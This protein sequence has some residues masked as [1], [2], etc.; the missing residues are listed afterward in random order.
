MSRHR[1]IALILGMAASLA[2]LAV[3]WSGVLEPVEAVVTDLQ[4]RL[5][6]PQPADERV[7]LVAVDAASIDALGRWPW[8]RTCLA[9]LV[10]RLVAADAR[11]V[12]FD[13]VLSEAT[14]SPPGVDLSGEDEALASSLA[15]APEVV[16][17][18]FFRHRLPPDQREGSGGCGP[19][20]LAGGIGECY[21]PP[22]AGEGSTATGP[23][24]PWSVQQVLGGP[25]PVPQ[26]P[27]VEANLELFARQVSAQGFFS[28][29]RQQG[30]QRRYELIN[31]YRSRYYPALALA[32]VARF[33]GEPV[34]LRPYQ[35]SLP[36]VRIGE[37]AVRADEHGRLWLNYRGGAGSFTT[38]SALAVLRG[39]VPAT[40]LADR[41]VFI[42]ATETGIGDIAATP[43][44]AEVPGVEVHATAADNLLNQR[45]LH[46]TALQYLV[47]L[48]ALLLL[49]PLVALLVSVIDRHL[50]GSLAA[51]ALVFSWPLISHLAFR[52]AGWHLQTV[53]PVLAGGVALVAALRY[54][55]GT[56]EAHARF[57]RRAF[58]RYV[59]GAVVD[60][61]VRHPHKL[62][63]GGEERIMT[64]LF[65]DIRGFT[66]LSEG[67]APE[68]LVGLLNQ[69]FTP[70]TRLV[71]DEGGTLDKYMGDALMALFGAPVEQPDHA[72]RA[73][74]AALQMRAELRLLNA[75]WHQE[76]LFEGRS[77]EIGIGIGINSG[78]MAVGN[79]GSDQVF[80]YTVI[81]DNVNLGSRIE[82]LNKLYGTEILCS[83]GTV[84]EVEALEAGFDARTQTATDLGTVDLAQG[85]VF[86]EVDR[87]RVKGKNEP[88][89]LYELVGQRPLPA[90]IQ[91][92][93]ETFGQG[94]AFYR[95]RRF[96]QAEALFLELLE[97]HG[98]DGPSR[99]F[100]ERCR[101]YLD[102]PPPEDW[103]GVETLTR[104]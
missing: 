33:T 71:L 66:T 16:L 38:F 51:I 27:A 86:R 100:L 4:M 54:Q 67:L 13:L 78:E 91:A 53:A 3:E 83:E 5:R 2:V 22:S 50:L 25:Y 29:E 12:A 63:L 84:R 61:L 28:H 81:G 74:H 1:I 85:L 98:E 64:V 87:V 20:P 72:L 49:G 40:A 69:F 88:V 37:Q 65:S 17:G 9:E 31:G 18:Y 45:F 11:V 96:H 47:S 82:G 59:S 58:Q 30:V 32:A 48:L 60:E 76:G 95:R 56:V 89:S 46:D 21:A 101:R 23:L 35:G 103:D 73:C 104:K 34:S 43:F 7:V 10:D 41:L 94:L 70:M 99:L 39:E 90:E 15:V 80:D 14:R 19:A 93:I 36:E 77:A 92:R 57:L 75:R 62:E 55:V 97:E 44:G 6:G 102:D 42:G 8:P 68:E 24:A 79:M 52:T 26:R